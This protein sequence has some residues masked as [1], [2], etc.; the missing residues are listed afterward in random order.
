[1]TGTRERTMAVGGQRQV[2]VPDPIARDYL[3]LALRL[4]QHLP[5]LVDAYFGPADLKA[6]TELEPERSPARLAEDA[7][8]L[9]DRLAAAVTDD[10]PPR[11]AGPAAPGAARRRH[12]CSPAT[13]CH[14]SSR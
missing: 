2:P 5:G 10:R 12:P 14:T 11:L 4:D 7:A 8:A 1:M 6:Q 9:R 3:L 13:T